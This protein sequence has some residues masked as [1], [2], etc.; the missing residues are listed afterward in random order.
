MKLEKIKNISEIITYQAKKRPNN[1]AVVTEN[2]VQITYK[3]LEELICKVSNYLINN[4]KV[5]KSEVVS[6]EANDE[7]FIL[8]MMLS[9][10]RVGATVISIPKKTPKILYEEMVENSNVVHKISHKNIKLKEISKDEDLLKK[11]DIKYDLDELCILIIGSGS[12]GKKKIIPITQKQEIARVKN[13][14][15]C[16]DVSADDRVST[17]V[18]MDFHIAKSIYLATF[19]TGGTVVL[20]NKSMSNFQTIY[21]KYNITHLHATVFFIGLL[22]KNLKKNGSYNLPNLKRL[23]VGGSTVSDYLRNQIRKRITPNLR[24]RY[25]INE[26]GTISRI[27]YEKKST[28]RS[29]GKVM[30]SVEV[31]IVDSN[32]KIVEKE[33]VGE[34]RIKSESCISYYLNDKE[35]SKTAFKNGWFYPK[36]LARF[37]KEGELVHMGRADEMMILNGI[38][39]YPIE[40]ENVM[41][42]HKDVD[43]VVVIPF[44]SSIHQD[45]PICAVVLKDNKKI[46]EEELY[47]YALERL[48][49]SRPRRIITLDKIPKNE[50]GKIIREELRKKIDEKM[51]GKQIKDEF[52]KMDNVSELVTYQSKVRPNDVVIY[53]KDFNVTYEELEFYIS[54]LAKWL[55][56]KGVKPKNIVGITFK[57][58]YLAFVSMLAIS[59]IGA[60]V[61][62][63]PTD[64]SPLQKKELVDEL[65]IKDIITDLRLSSSIANYLTISQ[66]TLKNSTEI[67]IDKKSFSSKKIP[68]ILVLGSGSTGKRKIIPVTNE[69]QIG[70]TKTSLDWLKNQTK[71]R[72][73]SIVHID[74]Y[75]SKV[76]YLQALISGSSIVF[77]NN[78][79]LRIL[80]FYKKYKITVLYMVVV[81]VQEVLMEFKNETKC[82]MPDIKTLMVDGSSVSDSLRENIRNKITPNIMVR[83]GINEIGSVTVSRPPHVYDTKNTVGFPVKNIELEIV[84]S[85]G[86]LQENNTIGEIR[87]KSDLAMTSYFNDGEATQKAFKDGWFYPKD[88][89]IFTDDGQ[90]I[91]K[92]RADDMMIMNGINIF[93]LEIEQTL[94]SHEDIIDAVAFP[95]KSIVHNDIPS[96]A[97]VLKKD[98]TLTQESIDAFCTRKLA[99]RRPRSIYILD[100][101]PRNQD[102]KVVKEQLHKKINNH[103]TPKKNKTIKAINSNVKQSRLVQYANKLDIPVLPLIKNSDY[104]QFGWG[105]NSQ[106][107]NSSSP[108]EDSFNGVK[109]SMDKSQSKTLLKN[110]GLPIVKSRIIKSKDNLEKISKIVGFPCVL[111]P[112]KGAAGIGITSNIQDL[113]DLENAYDFAKKSDF[114]KSSLI[115]EKHIEGDDYRIIVAY[116]KFLA[117]IK[118]TPASIIGDGNSS[119]KELIIKLN[120]NRENKSYLKQ[121]EFEKNLEN[122]LNRFDLNFDSILEKNKKLFL[123]SVANIV[124][125]GEGEDATSLIHPSLKQMAESVANV[126]KVAILGIDYI[127]TDA[128][129]PFNETNGAITEFNHYISLSSADFFYDENEFLR[130]IFNEVP[131]RIP[132]TVLVTN[133]KEQLVIESIKEKFLDE[134]G[135]GLV[136]SKEIFIEDI[137]LDSSNKSFRDLVEVLLR[138]KNLE[139]AIIICNENELIENNLPIDK[140]DS[141]YTHKVSNLENRIDFTASKFLNFENMT[142]LL[143]QCYKEINLSYEVTKNSIDEIY[144]SYKSFSLLVSSDSLSGN[145]NLLDEWFSKIL[146][147][148]SFET[149]VKNINFNNLILRVLALNT[150]LLNLIKIPIFNDGKI[151]RNSFLPKQKLYKSNIN[152]HAIDY[153]N[154]RVF[155]DLLQL[156]LKIVLDLLHK[157]ITSNS[158]QELYRFIKSKVIVP[159]A[160]V[161][162]SGKSTIPVLK[163]AHELNIPYM[164]LGAGVYQLGWASK[165]LRM[166]RSTVQ[167]DSAIGA[168][169]AQNKMTTTNLLKDAGLPCANNQLVNSKKD[170]LVIAK[171]IGFPVVVKP[172]D[173]DRG[174]GITVNVDS[175]EKLNKAYDIARKSSRSKRVIVE[176]QV[177]GV[178]HRLFIANGKLLYG[179]K[180]LPKG[181]YTDGVNT[182]EY[183]IHKANEKEKILPPWLKSEH[184]PKD[185]LALSVINNLGFNLDDI[186]PNDTFIPLREIETTRDGGVDEDVTKIIHEENLKAAIQAARLFGLRVSGIDIISADISKPFYENGAIINEVN[187]SP[188]FGGGEI[189]RA[190][191]PE[192]LKESIEL[193]GRIPITILENENE[194]KLLYDEKMSKG[195]NSS[196]INFDRDIK[197]SLKKAFLNP[198]LDEIILLKKK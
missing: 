103:Q 120:K 163:V 41:M 40:I 2:F 6:V 25:G 198:I 107:F 95:T 100:E 13:S 180:R 145:L 125:G 43:D 137:K 168:K 196:I 31:Q 63:I 179:V 150:K 138:Q 109:I 164:H 96:C 61:F 192:F 184:F 165:S 30:E 176:E 171:R 101:I 115:L 15:Q 157:E 117:A 16:F 108:F 83:Y 136:S 29:V 162:G 93:P 121:I 33:Q 149:K 1:I 156:S 54:N 66:N 56:S 65:N 69:Q 195:I 126:T 116:G 59:R 174:E 38:N 75:S 36:D 131:S 53:E 20:F 144:T 118:R 119:I 197:K 128:T 85:Q 49:S 68:W 98:S 122:H 175:E 19:Y 160:R 57:D 55:L 50:Q 142:D 124:N 183:L 82:M 187:F 161:S 86:M 44:K 159:Y 143:S 129:K 94:L 78:K 18:H 26:V 17:Y 127:T 3:D 112:I 47:N 10:M 155:N 58:E 102:G 148:K 190:A 152:L 181:L 172:S 169:L 88:L 151:V 130:R 39:I 110:L 42:N 146:E 140:V 105:K 154:Q 185:A 92:G 12:T 182:I 46:S 104:I 45:I 123:S 60:T 9:I 141:I 193:D 99:I 133:E 158:I 90:L 188:L 186:P 76:L 24:I 135:L 79:N 23:Y 5:K 28:Q 173:Q 84:D 67:L 139:K 153:I 70:R 7:F 35:A 178:C 21:E 167:Y 97:V 89:G 191:I 194:A 132:I 34:I 177:E 114:G 170:A 87:I 72:C 134:K 14:Y 73:S 74:S 8:V 80:D 77:F 32:D 106:L 37:T 27:D 22:L 189:S 62:S 11:I 166:D 71:D 91:F 64:T 113:N 52:D 48:G 111:K 147:I 81:Q 51:N 4:I